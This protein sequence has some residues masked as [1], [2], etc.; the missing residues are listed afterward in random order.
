MTR[1]G[2]ARRLPGKPTASANAFGT[3]FVSFR[4]GSS[5]GVA[6]KAPRGK[7]S[8]PCAENI[9]DFS[10]NSYA[11]PVLVPN[12]NPQGT[13]STPAGLRRRAYLNAEP[14]WIALN[15]VGV[16]VSPQHDTAGN[17]EENQKSAQLFFWQMGGIGA[18]LRSGDTWS[19]QQ[20]LSH[21]WYLLS[22]FPPCPS[23]LSSSV[24]F[25]TESLL[26]TSRELWN[27]AHTD[28]HPCHSQSTR[29]CSFLLL[30]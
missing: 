7:W 5:W 29:T 19:P 30:I 1:A 2:D 18:F 24:T 27:L 4:N 11:N 15:E 21:I 6:G 16:F 26:A 17:K 3:D 22:R 10:R 12:A 13:S 25:P 28:T 9:R 20:I 14:A 8:L 23:R